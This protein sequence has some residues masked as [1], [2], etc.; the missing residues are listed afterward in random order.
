VSGK[1]E[2]PRRHC[3]A[4]GQRVLVS[5]LGSHVGSERCLAAVQRRGGATLDPVR[6]PK[7]LRLARELAAL[8]RPPTKDVGAHEIV[9]DASGDLQQD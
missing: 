3:P 1:S 7:A 4:C 2:R 8:L 9:T 5:T 6:G